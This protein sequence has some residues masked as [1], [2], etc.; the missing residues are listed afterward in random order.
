LEVLAERK[1]PDEDVVIGNPEGVSERP[2]AKVEVAP[3]LAGGVG[4]IPRRRPGG[5]AR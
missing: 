5:A 1:P 3:E 4:C 2:A